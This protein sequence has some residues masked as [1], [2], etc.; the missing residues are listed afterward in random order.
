MKITELLIL[1]IMSAGLSACGSI[2]G[3]PTD[4]QLASFDLASGQS[5]IIEVNT[6]RINIIGVSGDMLKVDGQ[7]AFPGKTDYA[8]TESSNGVLI[9]A[10][11]TGPPLPDSAGPATTVNVRAPQDT[12]V[13]VKAFDAAVTI[14]EFRGIVEISSV[15]GDITAN[16]IDG[17]ASLR[18]ARGDAALT[19]GSGDFQLIGEHGI[20]FIE[21]VSGKVSAS[22]IMGTIRFLGV[23]GSTD[24][25]HLETDHGPVE[26][27]LREDSDLSLTVTST[28]GNVACTLPDLDRSVR[29]C[30]GT[31]GSGTGSLWVRTVSGAITIRRLP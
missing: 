1:A 12:P 18:T 23:P 17:T 29:G 7:L 8:V 24:E 28:S 22:T 14:N 11:Y 3:Q 20:L 15:A 19:G 6:G 25:I 5:V 10:N 4:I 27:Q 21:G 30:T 2:A 16:N 26:I 31:M 13:R 9:T